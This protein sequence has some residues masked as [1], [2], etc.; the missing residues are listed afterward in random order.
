MPKRT[1]DRAAVKLIAADI[2]D[3]HGFEQLTL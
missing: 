2:A 3:A 1:L